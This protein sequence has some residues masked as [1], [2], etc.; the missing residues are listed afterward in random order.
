MAISNRNVLS[1]T[2]QEYQSLLDEIM[3]T[4]REL[5]PEYTDDTDTD[6]GNLLLTYN[7][8]LA[9]VLSNK[10]DYS[11]NEAIPMLAETIKAMYK[12]CKWIGYKPESNKAA[13]TTFELLITNNGEH[14]TIEKG[15]Q[16]TMADMVNDSY[17][18]FE[19]D[20]NVDCTAPDGVEIDENY[21]VVCRG[22]QGESV[23]EELGVSDGK[24]DQTFFI[25]NY[26]YV[27]GS[28]EIE[29]I[30]ISGRRERYH[31][32]INN[33]FVYT[34]PDDKI[35][36]IECVDAFTIKVKF[37]DGYNGVIPEEGA[38]IIAHYRIGGGQIGNRPAGVINVPLFD[39]PENFISI[40]N[41]TDAVGGEDMFNVSAIKRMIEKGRHRTIYSLMRYQDYENFLDKP[42]RREYIGAFKV[43]RDNIEITRKFRPIG[44][45]LK[46]R[47]PKESF[48]F[49]D[50]K[51]QTL[52]DELNQYKLIDDE[53]NIYD[54]TPV[55]VKVHCRCKSDGLTV[56]GTLLNSIIY[57]IYEYIENMPIAGD[58]EIRND[59]VGLYADDIRSVVR[60]VEGVKRFVSLDVMDLKYP[61]NILL[62]R[63]EPV[64]D[65]VFDMTLARGQKL[66]IENIDTD[67]SVELV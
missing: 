18:I 28:L 21:R 19:I 64:N 10:L 5:M 4:K 48:V 27:E 13:V 2:N 53:I 61:D 52:L 51:K 54:V 20:E 56:V 49:P 63:K 35:I 26:P 24:E 67:I 38:S 22:I 62:Y 30:N 11:V 1:Y 34:K 41:V 6:F 42:E 3:A 39:M 16:V 29:V 31:V 9:D 37:G 32:N 23:T 59:F 57:A 17:V 60:E 46:P 14:Q 66:V 43:C 58:D 33:S 7:A 65:E 47:V 44:I 25:T 15:S 40:T 8:M 45:Y 12:H 50:D 55:Y 36:V